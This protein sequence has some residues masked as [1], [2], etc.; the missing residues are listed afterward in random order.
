ML[1]PLPL[2]QLPAADVDIHASTAATLQAAI[3][4]DA[5]AQMRTSETLQPL[6]CRCAFYAITNS[7]AFGDSTHCTRHADSID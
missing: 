1:V 5:A 2:F 6:V 7:P 4:F 3:P